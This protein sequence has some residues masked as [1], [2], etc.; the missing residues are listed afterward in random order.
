MFTAEERNLIAHFKKYYKKYNYNIRVL[1]TYDD[2]QIYTIDRFISF[3]ED[4]PSNRFTGGLQCLFSR[5]RATRKCEMENRQKKKREIELLESV[6]KNGWIT[7]VD[8]QLQLKKLD[9]KY[10]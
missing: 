2:E 6:Y 1:S 8:Y 5:R 3:V 9:D 10:N 4:L 7:E